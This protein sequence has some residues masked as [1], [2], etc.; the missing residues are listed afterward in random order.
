M[1]ELHAIRVMALMM[2][3]KMLY[4]KDD[5]D[6]TKRKIALDLHILAAK[7]ADLIEQQERQ[8]SDSDGNER[9]Y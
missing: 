3:Q 4:D 7:M 1:F 9:I 5:P 2:A 8:E 6:G